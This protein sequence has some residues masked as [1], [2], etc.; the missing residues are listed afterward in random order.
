MSI[1]NES[2]KIKTLCFTGYRPNKCPWGYDETQFA[3]LDMRSRTKTQILTAINKGYVNFMSG[4]ALGF[5]MICAELVLE[6]KI[7]CPQIKLICVLPCKNQSSVWHDKK[8]Q[9]RYKRILENADLTICLSDTYTPTCMQERNKFMVDNSSAIIGLYD[10]KTGGTQQTLNYA[11][12]Q[13][14]K[15]I[16]IKP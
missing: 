8:T 15:V 6:L 2:E 12:A 14:L 7:V 5:D 11:K 10:G 9:D 13:G 16:T 3:C 4:M 1:I